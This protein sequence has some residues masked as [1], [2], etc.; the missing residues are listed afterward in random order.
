MLEHLLIHPRTRSQ[1]EQFTAALSHGLVLTGPEGSGKKTLALEVAAMLLGIDRRTLDT[2][3]YFTVINPKEQTITIDEIR[4]VQ[5]LLTLR[6]P[7]TDHTI[8]R[9]IIVID[10]ERMRSEAQNAFL[11]SLEEPPADTCIIFTTG[12]HT[13]LLETIFSRMQ[14]IDV[15]PVSAAAAEKYY[16]S[17]G[18]SSSQLKSSFALSLGQVGLLHSLLHENE[19]HVLKE[20]VE[21]AKVLLSSQPGSRLL[22]V[23][24][25]SKDKTTVALLLNALG[26]ISH[27]ALLSSGRT[28]NHA[29]IKRW[30]RSSQAVIDAGDALRHNANTKLVLDHLFLHL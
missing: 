2:Y 25:L 13:G 1:I 30:A 14:R 6:T 10:A 8:R 7:H 9:V 5:K 11:K 26:R 29:S 17:Q 24:E 18:I 12:A 21:K 19:A 23:D 15:L 16:E 20:W 3:P 28:R 4:S 22:Q 27:A